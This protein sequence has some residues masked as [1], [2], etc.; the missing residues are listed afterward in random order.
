MSVSMNAATMNNSTPGSIQPTRR[1]TQEDLI[2]AKRRVDEKKKVAC[3][4]GE[5]SLLRLSRL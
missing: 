4:G 1:P 5:F 3:S 2:N